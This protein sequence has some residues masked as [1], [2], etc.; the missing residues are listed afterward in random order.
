M[1]EESQFGI[2]TTSLDEGTFPSNGDPLSLRKSISYI[3]TQAVDGEIDLSYIHR[4]INLKELI[5]IGKEQN[6]TVHGNGQV[7]KCI[8]RIRIE[9]CLVRQSWYDNCVHAG[10]NPELVKCR[11]V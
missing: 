6:V 11:L 1:T 5:I 10:N 4:C 9:D 2:T 7:P 8:D 3:A